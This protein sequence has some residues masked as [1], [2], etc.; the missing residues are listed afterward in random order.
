[1]HILLLEPVLVFLV[2]PVLDTIQDGPDLHT[3]TS[4]NAAGPMDFSLYCI[5]LMLTLM[6]SVYV[7]PSAHLSTP[8]L[9][10]MFLLCP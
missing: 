2:L 3:R 6:F 10:Y 9:T 8:G 4:K 7:A 5:F 1:M